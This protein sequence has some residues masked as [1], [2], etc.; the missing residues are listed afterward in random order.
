[1]TFNYLKIEIKTLNLMYNVTDSQDEGRENQFDSV[2]VCSRHTDTLGI[3]FKSF[4][5]F[6]QLSQGEDHWN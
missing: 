2:T 4:I 3:S 5:G 1:M 6:L